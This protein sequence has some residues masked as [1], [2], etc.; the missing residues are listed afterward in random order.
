MKDQTTKKNSQPAT[1]IRHGIIVLLLGTLLTSVSPSAATTS[2]SRFEFPEFG[3]V[4]AD[5]QDGPRVADVT[6][7]G[8]RLERYRTVDLQ[9]GDVIMAVNGQRL[10]SVAELRGIIDALDAGAEVKMAVQRFKSLKVAMFKIGTEA[11]YAAAEVLAANYVEIKA[12]AGS[13]G[14]GTGSS[15]MMKLEPGGNGVPCVDLGAMLDDSDGQIRVTAI[16]DLPPQ[17]APPIE[18]SDGDILTAFQGQAISKTSELMDQYEKIIAGSTIKLALVRDNAETE[19]TFKK[20]ATSGC[21]TKVIK[22]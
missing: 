10:S 17:I 6:P 16:I 21:T 20:P 9:S 19:L 8:G 3:A 7:V 12:Q 22:R 5:G 1:G 18:L 14:S 15:V 13:C 11:D 4:I 2:S